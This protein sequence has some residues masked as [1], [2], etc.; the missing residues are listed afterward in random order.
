MRLLTAATALFLTLSHAHAGHHEKKAGGAFTGQKVTDNIYVIAGEGGNIG[1]MTG[2]N[3]AFM[4]DDKFSHTTDAVKKAVKDITDKPVKFL[5]NTHYHFDHAG[6]NVAFGEEGAVIF[7]HDNV[8]KRLSE[9]QVIELFNKT[10]EP[11]AAAGLPVI[12]F[13]E[14]M[15]LHLGGDTV[16]VMHLPGAHTDGDSAVYFKKAD[17]MHTGDAFFNG[18]Y[19]FIDTGA[20]GSLAGAVAAQEKLLAV[21]GDNTNI[22]PGHGPVATRAELEATKNMLKAIGQNVEKLIAEG[23]TREEIIAAKPTAA[24]DSAY[25]GGFMKPDVF[26]GIVYDGIVEERKRR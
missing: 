9:T 17:V 13:P 4:I 14:S 22:I 26:A 20:G 11:T 16:E 12:T 5:L 7:S 18:F 2:E 3:G 23:K 21:A 6:G 15:T 25:G 19:P 24:F 10:L 1:L 8:R